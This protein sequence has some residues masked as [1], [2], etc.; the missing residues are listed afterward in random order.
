MI[1][2]NYASLS[3]APVTT[4][5][6][7]NQTTEQRTIQTIKSD[8]MKTKEDTIANDQITGNIIS[9]NVMNRH[10][11]LKL[12]NILTKTC[13]ANR[14]FAISNMLYQCRKIDYWV[15]D[16]LGTN[17]PPPKISTP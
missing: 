9:I 3:N 11:M 4:E 17:S 16:T 1:I 12:T 14:G 7:T 6:T 5:Q 13:I 10:T 15:D 8:T 2:Y